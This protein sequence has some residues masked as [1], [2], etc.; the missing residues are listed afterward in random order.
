M[1][2][3]REAEEWMLQKRR[4]ALKPHLPGEAGGGHSPFAG[5]SGML[6]DRGNK[7]GYRRAADVRYR[8]IK[9]DE[10]LPR[11]YRKECLPFIQA[12]ITTNTPPTHHLF[13]RAHN[14]KESGI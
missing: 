6:R 1:G 4:D 3:E 10:N 7:P 9:T 14:L 12:E 8:H 11:N 2:L 5:M 13:K